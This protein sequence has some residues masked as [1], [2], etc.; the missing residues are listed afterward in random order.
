MVRCLKLKG[1]RRKFLS[2][3]QTDAGSVRN[4]PA[5]YILRKAEHAPVMPSVCTH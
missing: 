4:R 2:A 1:V 3:T 5:D